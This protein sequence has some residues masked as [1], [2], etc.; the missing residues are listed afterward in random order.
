MFDDFTINIV[1]MRSRWIG[2]YFVD[3]NCL[4]GFLCLRGRWLDIVFAMNAVLE[5]MVRCLVI[6]T[7][8]Y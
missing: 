3:W 5:K 4:D 7:H 6:V 1:I 2:V 8:I